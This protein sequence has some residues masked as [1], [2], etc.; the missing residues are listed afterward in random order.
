MFPL[1]RILLVVFTVSSPTCL[2]TSVSG[3]TIQGKVGQ[4]ITLPCHYSTVEN[5]IRTICWGRASCPL[6]W[7]SSQIFDTSEWKSIYKKDSKYYLLGDVH[8]GDVSLTIVNVTE[9]DSGIYCCRVDISG[10]F[11]DLK[12]NIEVVIEKGNWSPTS[13]R[14]PATIHFTETYFALEPRWMSSTQS[15]QDNISVHFTTL[16]REKRKE[17]P[18]RA[19]LY[20]GT[21]TCAVVLLLIVAMLTLKWYLHKKQRMSNSISQVAISSSATGGIRHVMETGVRAPENIYEMD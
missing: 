4:N 7:C 15:P 3:S 1:E 2:L 12:H 9:E 8:Q 5:G 16:K 13:A 14:V 21:G 11:N 10:W 18:S 19:V 20:I 17:E 6:S